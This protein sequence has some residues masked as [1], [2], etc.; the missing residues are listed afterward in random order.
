MTEQGLTRRQ[1]LAAGVGAAASVL[2]GGALFR[3]WDLLGR[4]DLVP[5]AAPD[6]VLEPERWVVT[7]DRLSFAV[8]GD[9]GSGGRQAIEVAEAMARSYQRQP[10]GL[11]SMLGDICYYGPIAQRFDD[12]F[13]RP[14]RPLIDAG[15]RFELAVGNHDGDIFFDEG[16]PDVEATLELLGTPARFYSISRG[17]VDFF[18]LDSGT[19]GLLGRDGGVQLEWLDDAL[20][21]A[22]SRWKVVC[23]HHPIYSS[24]VHGPTERLD[25]LLEPVLTRH[26]VDL[27]LAGH[28]HHYERTAPIH[29]IT[30]VVSGGGCKLTPVSPAPYAAVAA[31]TLQF[32]RFDV[33]GDRLT[34]RSIGVDGQ[35]LDR[36][37]LRAREGR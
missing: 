3:G 14:M 10:F 15:V 25:V 11:V 28:D 34:G 29:G 31:S 33:D 7:D 18:Y 2:T 4:E 24:G 35:L 27:V 16:V 21:S 37:E 32:M 17:P 9:N 1:V 23:L 6:I 13:V 36:F 19:L 22:T 20:A 8:I 12:V 26:A 5:G 30:H